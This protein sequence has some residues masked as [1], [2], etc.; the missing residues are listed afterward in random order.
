M[1]ASLLLRSIYELDFYHG[2]RLQ[3]NLYVCIVDSNLK[4][5][6][7]VCV[8]IIDIAQKVFFFL[9]NNLK[10]LTIIKHEKQECFF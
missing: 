10:K 1:V 8:S 2:F 4:E 6:N 5:K 3:M 9:T 7:I